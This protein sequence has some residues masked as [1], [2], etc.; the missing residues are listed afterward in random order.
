[1]PPRWLSVG[2]IFGWLAAM[3]WL[4]WHDLW[5]R[6]RPG[7]PPPFAIDL[8]EE[9]HND[10]LYTQWHVQHQKKDATEPVDVFDDTKTWV[11]Y[12][13][14]DDTFTLHAELKSKSRGKKNLELLRFRGSLVKVDSLISSYRVTRAGQ[15]QGLR[16]QMNFTVVEEKSPERPVDAEEKSPERP[17]DA[18]TTSIQVVLHG[19]VRGDQFFLS[20]RGGPESLS[21]PIEMD[22]PPVPLSHNTSMLLPLHPVNRIHGLRPGQSWRQP[23]IDPLHDALGVGGVRYLNA[24]VLPQPQILKEDDNDKTTCLVIEYTDEDGQFAGRTWVE[25]NSERVQQQEAVRDGDRWIM[26]RD[27]PR[28]A[29]K[30][31]IFPGR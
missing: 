13:Q 23:L 5:P 22:L 10:R 7:E 8:V 28:R 17:V 14:K 2:I 11:S 9:V 4:F 27:N 30:P 31:S 18:K 21:R 15:L 29:T 1:M 26:K 16:S 19:E 6:W 3:G 12:Q 24:R 20:C 25:Q